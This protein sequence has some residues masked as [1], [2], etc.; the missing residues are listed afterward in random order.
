MTIEVGIMSQPN[1]E[2]P[3]SSGTK[4]PF[5][6]CVLLSLF[7]FPLPWVAVYRVERAATSHGDDGHVAST[8]GWQTGFH[9]ALGIVV[10]HSP[11]VVEV[12]SPL[13]P[14]GGGGQNLLWNCH[15]LRC[16]SYFFSYCWRRYF[17]AACRGNQIRGSCW[18]SRRVDSQYWRRS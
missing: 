10:E 5:V 8:V 2:T 14:H 15:P 7:M 4:I 16:C 1:G 17:I 3:L 18:L 12:P 11:S 9:A 13:A 6:L